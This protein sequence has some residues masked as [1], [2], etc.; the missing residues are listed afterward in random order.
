MGF[1][2]RLSQAVK[3]KQNA[4]CVGIDPRLAQLPSSL[5]ADV[6]DEQTAADAFLTF[7]KSIIDVVAPLVPVV[8]PQ[9]AFFEEL[10]P[11]G[12]VAM[13]E[14]IRYA[15]EKGL[16]VILDGKRNDIGSTATAYARAYMG[17][18]SPFGADALTVSPY[19]GAD[20]L[21]PFVDRCVEA[22]AGIFVLVKTSNPGSG[23]MQDRIIDGLTVAER[24]ADLVQEKAAATASGPDAYG[25]IGCVVGATYP[26]QLA[27]MRKRMPNAWIL[28]PGYGAQGGGAADV[29]HGFDASGLGALVN[30]S[31]GIIFAYENPKYSSLLEWERSVEEATRDMILELSRP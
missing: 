29:K 19:L 15:S 26:E 3:E 30:S 31:R 17:A 28:I 4:V 14:V 27:A 13:R 6:R 20:S 16:L 24:V 21:E 25:S 2:D 11:L 18:S 23:F 22:D 1:G 8:K 9:S 12:L 7:S 10:G 5:T